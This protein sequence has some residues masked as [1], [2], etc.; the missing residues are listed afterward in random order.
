MR[1]KRLWTEVRIINLNDLHISADYIV[2]PSA[3]AP[4]RKPLLPSRNKQPT[5]HPTA[6]TNLLFISD[7]PRS[8]TWHSTE[9]RT[10]RYE[11]FVNAL[12][13]LQELE[14]LSLRKAVW[15]KRLFAEEIVRRAGGELGLRKV[16][17]TGCGMDPTHQ[18]WTKKWIA[19]R[20]DS[21][22]SLIIFDLW[23]FKK[24][25]F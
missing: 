2:L 6:F 23:I 5:Y 3:S 11:E 4:R 16:N 22:R 7:V 1:F 12:C 14:I 17:F 10:L 9:F 13:S 24:M 25:G 15:I 19:R 8:N 18:S 20:N 21:I